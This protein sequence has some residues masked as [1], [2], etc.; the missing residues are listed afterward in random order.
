MNER[1]LMT[2]NQAQNH[3]VIL[4]ASGLSHRLGQPKQLL[5]KQGEPLISYMTAL[6][7]ATQPQ[8]I[9]VVI[10]KQ[11]LAIRSAIDTLI[12]EPN[13]QNPSIEIVQNAVPQT[14]MASSLSLAID[15]LRAQHDLAIKRV[16][17]MGVDQVLLDSEHLQQLL[18]QDNLVVASCYPYLEDN[19][20]VD[21][22][23]RNIVGVPLVVN[24]Q[25]LK[26]WQSSL[27]GDKGL[28]HFIR[29][30]APE[31]ITTIDNSNMRYDIDTPKQLAY[32]RQH[33]WLD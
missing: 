25:V 22:N 5:Q 26:S 23:K 3:A 17:I 20:I 27:T 15:A 9:I 10:P 16:L 6:A 4:L 19:L 32:A 13:P 8:T 18:A 2:Q 14:G 28:R 31:K 33:G 21:K 24:Y 1:S 7:L 11:S 30:L 29:A 12:D